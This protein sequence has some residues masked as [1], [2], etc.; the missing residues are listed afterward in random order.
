MRA[1]NIG[2]SVCVCGVWLAALAVAGPAAAAAADS[3]TVRVTRPA[4]GRIVLDVADGTVAVRKEITADRSVVTLTTPK[5]QLSIT[6]RRGTLVVSGPAGTVTMGGGAGA[7]MDADRLLVMLQRSDAAAKARTLLA[8]VSEGPGTF[9]GQSVLLTR[10][11]LEVG[12]GSVNALSQH[13]EWVAERAAQNARPRQTQLWP[14]VT[15]VG[16]LEGAQGPGDCWDLYSKEAIRIADDFSECTDG[17]AWY[18]AH[19][20][21]GCALIYAVRSEGAMAWFISCNG[22]IPFNA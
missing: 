9:A 21:A 5:D 1:M 7:G 15:R 11:I 8:A 22:G 6:V 20:W 16:Y 2:K 13:Q 3:P 19:K 14:K 18:E 4:P 17:L 10:A 12:S